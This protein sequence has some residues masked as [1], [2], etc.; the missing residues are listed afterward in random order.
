MVA[1]V[2]SV[3]IFS[4]RLFSSEMSSFSVNEKL[5]RLVLCKISIKKNRVTHS[6]QEFRLIVDI[7]VVGV[8]AG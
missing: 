6:I 8:E 4:S 7:E 2:G 5:K 1:V 3:S